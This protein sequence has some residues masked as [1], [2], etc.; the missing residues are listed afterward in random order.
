LYTSRFS[1]EQKEKIQNISK[2]VRWYRKIHRTLGITILIILV[3]S[4]VTGILLAWKKDINL[5]QPETQNAGNTG[6]E[7]WI[8]YSEIAKAADVA[9]M[10]HPEVVAI[11]IDR[12]DYRPEKSI[13]K[14]IYKKGYW[15][16]QVNCVNGDILSVQK[17]YSDLFE[18]I[19]DGSIIGDDLSGNHHYC[20]PVGRYA[21]PGQTSL[22][23][24]FQ[25]HHKIY[26]HYLPFE[27]VYR[28]RFQTS[29]DYQAIPVSPF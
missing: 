1:K 28:I 18:G 23:I 25:E 19:H 27:I 5:I 22:S 26:T 6:L 12:M 17:R 15:E 11:G 13:V 7:N 3:I 8:S 4:S 9:L 16:V 24:R 2:K 10:D 14:V 21:T 29:A 20:K